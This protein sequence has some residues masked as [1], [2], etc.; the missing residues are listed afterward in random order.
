MILIHDMRDINDLNLC[1]VSGHGTYI[2]YHLYIYDTIFVLYI[3][4]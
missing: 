2:C 3:Y 4:L 1:I